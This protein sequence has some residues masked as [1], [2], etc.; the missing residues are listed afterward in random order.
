MT[1]VTVPANTL[2]AIE[3][4]TGPQTVNLTVYQGDDF[5]L[6]LTVTD[7]NNNPVP[8]VGWTAAAQVR[9]APGT[10]V[11]ATF[12][13]SIDVTVTNRV[14]LRL[15]H[16]EAVKLPRKARWDCQV[17]DPNGVVTTLVAGSVEGT[18]EITV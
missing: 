10:P 4:V 8:M 2:G 3:V 7:L 6:Y 9:A 18:Q 1:M 13:A 15:P 5:F 16:L 11:V 12:T 17:I 14:N